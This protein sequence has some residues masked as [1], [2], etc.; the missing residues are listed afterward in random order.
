MLKA[1]LEILRWMQVFLVEYS[2]LPSEKRCISY[3][4]WSG[5]MKNTQNMNNSQNLILLFHPLR[6]NKFS[7]NKF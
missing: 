5:V 1:F 6:N 2:I 7:K 4:I 3:I